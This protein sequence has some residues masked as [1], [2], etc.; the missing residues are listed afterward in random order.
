MALAC[1]TD[2][3]RLTATGGRSTG[4]SIR[5][6]D[7]DVMAKFVPYEAANMVTLLP[8]GRLIPATCAGV[9]VEGA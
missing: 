8:S 4:T 6:G 5:T 9:V 7:G 3:V 2:L 1:D